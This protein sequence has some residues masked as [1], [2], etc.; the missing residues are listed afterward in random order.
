[1]E[2]CVDGHVNVMPCH[3]MS[4]HAVPCQGRARCGISH[5]IAH[6]MSHVMP[7]LDGSIRIGK[8]NLA[9]LAGS[10]RVE[11]TNAKGEVRSLLHM[12]L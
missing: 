2:P 1:M 7:W 10:E 9:D 8:L 3:A 11:K 12:I 5:G 4:C 6:E